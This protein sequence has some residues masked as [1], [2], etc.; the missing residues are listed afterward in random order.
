MINAIL[1]HGFSASI[2]K[3]LL[4]ALDQREEI[5]SL[6]VDNPD[7]IESRAQLEKELDAIKSCEAFLSKYSK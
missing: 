7:M 6:V 3:H 5:D 4:D 1:V 2:K